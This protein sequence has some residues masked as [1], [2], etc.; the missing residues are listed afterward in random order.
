MEN[1]KS[2]HERLRFMTGMALLTAIIV[3]L[4]LFGSS[5]RIGAI[6]FSL[7]LV[8]IV[9]GAIVYGPGAG[10]FLGGVFGVVTIVMGAVGADQFT[11][12]LWTAS[13]FGTILICMAKGCAAGLLAGIVYKVARGP[14]TLRCLLASITAPIANTGVFSIGMLTI[15]RDSLESFASSQGAADAVWFLFMVMIGV[16]FLVEL[17]LN[18][19]LSTAISRVARIV[20]KKS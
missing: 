12:F 5:F 15:L 16:N 19:V 20:M 9:L 10:A 13:P 8:P 18:V 6:P 1:R 2:G 4:Q 3:V 11:F 17:A 14:E 7:V